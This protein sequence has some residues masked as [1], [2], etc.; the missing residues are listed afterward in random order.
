L[1]VSIRPLCEDNPGKGHDLGSAWVDLSHRP[2]SRKFISGT[3]GVKDDRQAAGSVLV[4]F[5]ACHKGLL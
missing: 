2:H 1:A 3:L 5:L 4:Q